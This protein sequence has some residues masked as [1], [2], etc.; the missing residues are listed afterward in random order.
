MANKELQKRVDLWEK[1]S[2]DLAATFSVID[3]NNPRQI[4]LIYPKPHLIIFPYKPQ[5]D[6]LIDLV[7]EPTYSRFGDVNSFLELYNKYLAY[8]RGPGKGRG[9]YSFISEM[10]GFSKGYWFNKE[11]LL[12]VLGE[13][14]G[15]MSPLEISYCSSSDITRSPLPFI[16]NEKSKEPRRLIVGDLE[17]KGSIGRKLSIPDTIKS[18]PELFNLL[19]SVE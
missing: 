4:S 3:T 18:T 8:A 12:T 2:R 9:Y 19:K 16:L 7:I 14:L 13:F 17:D 6:Q 5:K 11:N 10:P 1:A 15:F